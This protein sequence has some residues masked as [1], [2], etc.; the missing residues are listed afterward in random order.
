MAKRD[1]YKPGTRSC[2]VKDI[3]GVAGVSTATVSRVINH[4]DGVSSEMRAAVMSAISQLRYRPNAQAAELGR[5]NGGI[6]RRR[7][8]YVALSSARDATSS[9]APPAVG[10]SSPAP[11]S[12]RTSS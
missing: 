5:R 11:S 12:I 3:A 6:A 1:A 4:I 2:T 7:G 10:R 8:S 9:A